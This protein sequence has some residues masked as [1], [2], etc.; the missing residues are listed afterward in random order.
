MLL[1]ALT[2]VTKGKTG[3]GQ[4]LSALFDVRTLRL[5]GYS[6]L[7]PR[8]V[9][10]GLPC[11]ATPVDLPSARRLRELPA[12]VR[13]GEALIEA[14]RPPVL[15]QHPK[16][17]T[18]ID[19]VR[20]TPR[21]HLGHE[22]NA[23]TPPLMRGSDVDV[24]EKRSPGRVVSTVNA[25]KANQAIALLGQN[26]ELIRCWRRQ[27]FIPYTKPVLKHVTVE[28]LIPVGPAIVSPPA[29]GVQLGDGHCVSSGGFRKRM[30]ETV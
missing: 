3:D 20:A 18:A 14:L 24:V 22:R 7:S 2:P 21:S 15:L 30:V 16:I 17:E 12:L 27:P 6:A 11:I 9:R 8:D 29:L 13:G 4:T 5:E 19:V 26:D 28:I 25:G 10:S 23:N 1:A